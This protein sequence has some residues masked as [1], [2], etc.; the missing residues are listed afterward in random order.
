[1]ARRKAHRCADSASG[2]RRRLP[3]GTLK[4]ALDYYRENMRSDGMALAASVHTDASTLVIWGDHD[5]ALGVFLP[6][7]LPRHTLNVR[8]HRIGKASHWVQNE[9]PAEVNRAPLRFLK[10]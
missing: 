3:P 10:A 4:A 9:A 2:R 8:I 7:G 1:M 5:P 6:E